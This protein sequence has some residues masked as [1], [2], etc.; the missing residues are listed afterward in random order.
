MHKAVLEEAARQQQAL[1]EPIFT[2]IGPTASLAS[3]AEFATNSPSTRLPELTCD[4]EDG[5]TFDGRFNLYEA[6]TAKDGSALDEAARTRLIVSKLDAAVYARF[7]NHILLK[8]APEVCVDDI[9]RTL[10]ELFQHNTSMFARRYTYL[11]TK[12]NG[13]SLIVYTGMLSGRHET[14]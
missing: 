14:G 13:D 3:A 7:T 2:A 5:C 9:V 12:R 8:I 6:I 1:L 11:R 4:P 10:K